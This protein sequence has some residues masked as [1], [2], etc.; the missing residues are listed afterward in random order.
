MGKQGQPRGAQLCAV[1][2]SDQKRWSQDP[3][4]T[5]LIFGLAE[6]VGGSVPT[7]GLPK[8]SSFSFFVSVSMV[9]AFGLVFICCSLGL[10]PSAI[11][12][13]LSIMLQHYR[14]AY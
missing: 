11:T 3:P 14:D 2:L 5:D 7:G 12:A 10:C 4:L 8:V 13:V 9:A 6:E 1:Y